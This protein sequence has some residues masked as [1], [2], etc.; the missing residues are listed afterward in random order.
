[1]RL[2][3][4]ALWRAAVA[5]RA[6]FGIAWR[7]PAESGGSLAAHPPLVPFGGVTQETPVHFVVWL[8]VGAAEYVFYAGPDGRKARDFYQDTLHVPGARGGRCVDFRAAHGAAA[9]G[10]VRSAWGELQGRGY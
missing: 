3:L 7:M 2:L 1:V 6:G 9:R 4:R 5:A 8:K 10:K